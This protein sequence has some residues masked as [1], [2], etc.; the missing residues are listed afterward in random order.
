MIFVCLMMIWVKWSFNAVTL[1]SKLL[2]W[3]FIYD[4]LL[5]GCWHSCSTKNKLKVSK[6]I[7]NQTKFQNHNIKL[8]HAF[9]RCDLN[10]Q[11]DGWYRSRILYPNSERRDARLH[12]AS[13]QKTLSNEKLSCSVTQFT[14]STYWN[15]LLGLKISTVKT[16]SESV[17][18]SRTDTKQVIS[19][20]L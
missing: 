20:L 18:E 6:D 12:A 2:S 15:K 14:V 9:Q 16:W 8:S 13:I 1:R 19:G 5:F 7:W 17:E 4:S 11:T 3:W 10:T